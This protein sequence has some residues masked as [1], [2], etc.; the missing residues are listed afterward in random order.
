MEEKVSI[1]EEYCITVNSEQAGTGAV[2]CR[3]T[4]SSNAQ[5]SQSDVDIKVEDN[6]NG[7]FSIFYSV[8]EVG[9][10]TINVNFGGNPVPG[11][12]FSM[13]VRGSI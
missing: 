12:S 7:T 10:Y 5:Q 3:I 8:K 6:G 1:G 2:T 4:S 13:K 9:D 11:G